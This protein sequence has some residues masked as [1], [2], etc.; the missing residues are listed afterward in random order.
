MEAR[1]WGICDFI[2]VS[3][4]AYVDH[5]SF[6][7]A[8]LCRFLE[9]AGFRVGI[10]AQPD[11]KN[12]S[13]YTVLGRPRLAFLVGS[14]NM[15]SMVSNYTAAR[16]KRSDDAYSPGGAGGRR[17]DRALL[18][19]PQGIR[20]AYKNAAVII[21]G[22][23]ASLRRFSH[24]DYWSDLVRR[25]ILLDSKADLLVYGMGERALLEIARRLAA[26]EAASD[27]R[28]VRGTCARY[29]GGTPLEAG[30]WKEVAILPEH[31]EVKGNDPAALRSFARQFMMQEQCAD[32]QSAGTLA[33]RNDGDR[34][35][36]QNPPAFPLER[37]ELDAL[38]DLP[39]TRRAHPS[40]EAAGGVPALKEVKFSLVASRGC[41]G[42]CSF[43]SI[44]AHQ[45]RAV[46]SRSK[47]SL[48]REASRLCALPDF[49]GYIH[50]VGGPTAN[51]YGAA[52]EKQRRGGFCAGRQCLYPE[53]CPKLKPGH[54]EYLEVLAALRRLGGVKKVFIRSGIRFDFI[55]MDKAH[56]G[57]FLEELCRHHVSGQLKVAPEHISK[58]VLDAMG[59]NSAAAGSYEAFKKAFDEQ[60]R[61]L[62]LKQ[63]LLPYF[64]SGH[65]GAS[66]EEA[67]ELARYLKKSG[68]TPEQ[69]QDFYPTPGTMSAVMFRTGLDPRNMEPIYVPFG[70]RERRLQRAALGGGSPPARKRKRE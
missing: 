37:A 61:R 29:H 55:Q 52:C 62:G 64:M 16:R 34:W 58:K 30:I 59:K 40:Y 68:F 63:Y 27:I 3:G 5:P 7:C 43:C 11:W 31:D 19:Y 2:F 56:G 4:D 53:P 49:K 6:S 12:P 13:S 32:P 18:V 25:S 50:D 66:T 41:F 33:Q 35:V 24:Y 36:I 10:I 28:D 44:S 1:G 14:G 67:A 57:K 60:N 70:E 45:G 21:G 26:G 38:Y 15:D 9:N 17:P 46:K 20:Q 48:I 22:I 47:E 65:P 51:F 42:G 69:S 8:L 23:E 54:K 39:F